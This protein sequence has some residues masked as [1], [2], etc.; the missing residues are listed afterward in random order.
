MTPEHKPETPGP[1]VAFLFPGQGAQAVGMGREL[2]D[3]SPAA[4]SVFKQVDAALGRP[5]TQLMFNGPEEELRQTVNA[6]PA[7]MAVSLAC[8][9]AMEERLGPEGMFQPVLMAGHSLGEYTA[10]AVAGVLDVAQTVQLV[11]VRGELMQEA[12]DLNP[13][14]MA[15]VLGLDEAEVEEI[16]RESGACVSSIN[17][18]AQMVLSGEPSAVARAMELASARGA[19]KVIPL[20]VG[21]AFHSDLMESAKMGLAEAVHKLRFSHPRVPIVANYTGQPLTSAQAIK[22]ELVSQICG[23]VQWKQSIDYMIDSGVSDFIEVGPGKALSGMVKQISESVNVTSVG[24]V[25]S[26]ASLDRN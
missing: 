9:K 11:Q 16:A 5:L 20:R 2:Y 22:R 23:C 10:L 13:G 8:F 21:G 3:R 4:R 1:K 6:Q 7:I 19:K 26:I 14:T 17:T 18:S 25:S 15:A 12:C 24:D